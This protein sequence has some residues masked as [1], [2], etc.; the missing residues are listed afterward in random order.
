MFAWDARKAATNANK[1]GVSFEEAV[2]GRLL[3]VGYTLRRLGDVENIRII[4]ARQ[5]SRKER[6]AYTTAWD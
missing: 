1:H 5:P 2:T 6:A 3:I 4:T